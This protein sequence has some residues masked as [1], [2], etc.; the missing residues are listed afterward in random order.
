[1]IAMKEYILP[2]RD[3]VVHPDMTVPLY[4]DNPVSISCIKSAAGMTQRVVIVPQH[5]GSY[6]TAPDDLYEYGT[7]GDVVQLLHMPDG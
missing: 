4:I 7:I 6:P 3:L 1:M 5:R 2:C